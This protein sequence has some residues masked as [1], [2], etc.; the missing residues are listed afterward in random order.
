MPVSRVV[1]CAGLLSDLADQKG[2][3]KG[4]LWLIWDVNGAARLVMGPPPER[5]AAA[6]QFSFGA[7]MAGLGSH[8]LLTV[9]N[10][11][12]SP[13]SAVVKPACHAETGHSLLERRRHGLILHTSCEKRHAMLVGRAQREGRCCNAP[14][15]ELRGLILLDVTLP[16]AW[17]RVALL[18][19]GQRL[20]EPATRH[21][22]LEVQGRYVLHEISCSTSPCW[23]QGIARILQVYK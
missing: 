19:F 20:G 12:P 18:K 3:V 11:P 14:A 9:R 6:E 7:Q 13:G 10:L 8:T 22:F 21:V 16:K 17:E 15:D 4:H 23:S 2:M 5:G 1:R